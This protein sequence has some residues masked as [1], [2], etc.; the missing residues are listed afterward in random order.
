M[1]TFPYDPADSADPC[2]LDRWYLSPSVP[3][4]R[5]PVGALA[6]TLPS[7]Q[8]SQT[9]DGYI[10]EPCQTYG[11]RRL[12]AATVS[13][14]SNLPEATWIDSLSA[15]RN[16]RRKKSTGRRRVFGSRHK[17]PSRMFP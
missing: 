3:M 17:P 8:A 2:L 16:L 13:R 10:P 1:A 4:D 15:T 6:E 9:G 12:G 14:W 11:D 7:Q 5:V